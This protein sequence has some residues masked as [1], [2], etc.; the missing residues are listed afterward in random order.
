MTFE[1]EPE[2]KDPLFQSLAALP[3]EDIDPPAAGLIRHRAHAI[4]V[5]RAGR[6]SPS[7]GAEVLY[8]WLLRPAVAFTVGGIYLAWALQR[9]FVLIAG[10]MA[11]LTP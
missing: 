9:A 11:V 6:A 5:R 2:E 1:D 7:A 4:L 8:S 10:S 3:G